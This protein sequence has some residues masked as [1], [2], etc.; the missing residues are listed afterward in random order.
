MPYFDGVFFERA[1]TWSYENTTNE[2]D[3]EQSPRSGRNEV[4]DPK[5]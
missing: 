2:A 3:G 5:G 4:E 1:Q